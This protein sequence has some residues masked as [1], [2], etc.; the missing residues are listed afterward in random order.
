MIPSHPFHFFFV[1]AVKEEAEMS[2]QRIDELQLE[3]KML[4]VDKE[5]MLAKQTAM[6]SLLRAGNNQHQQDDVAVERSAHI[7]ELYTLSTELEAARTET[8]IANGY[9][10]TQLGARNKKVKA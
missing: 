7:A 1:Q 8:D 4:N 6:E 3:L 10:Q 9:I 2:E 5:V